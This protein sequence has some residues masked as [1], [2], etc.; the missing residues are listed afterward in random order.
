MLQYTAINTNIIFI[1]SLG[2]DYGA[3]FLA[4]LWIGIFTNNFPHNY[5]THI[6]AVAQ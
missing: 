3:Y 4:N 6:D 2:I 1:N 5:H